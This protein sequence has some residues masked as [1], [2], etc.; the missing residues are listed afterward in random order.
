M[1]INDKKS[2]YWDS[3]ASIEDRIEDLLSQMTLEEKI[4]QLGSQFGYIFL[5][6]TNSISEEHGTLS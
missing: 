6:G 4:A 3:N 2:L 5:E 1:E